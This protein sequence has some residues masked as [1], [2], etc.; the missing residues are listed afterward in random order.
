[1][2]NTA[3]QL[4]AYLFTKRGS[5]VQCS[6]ATKVVLGEVGFPP[7]AIYIIYFTHSLGI[8]HWAA[9]ATKT[10]FMKIRGSES[11]SALRVLAQGEL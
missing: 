8:A 7:T 3:I 1:M 9:R 5:N 6:L 11:A 10:T 2:A 4:N